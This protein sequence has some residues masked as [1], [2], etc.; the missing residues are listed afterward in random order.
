MAKFTAVTVKPIHFQ[1][2]EIMEE[3]GNWCLISHGLDKETDKFFI[4]LK[5]FT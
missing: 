5:I 3:D 4:D 2:W 1:D